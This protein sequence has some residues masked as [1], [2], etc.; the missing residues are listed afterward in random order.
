MKF[1]IAAAMLLSAACASFALAQDADDKPA[2]AVAIVPPAI[3]IAPPTRGPVVIPDARSMASEQEI[4]QARRAYRAQCSRHESTAFCECVTAGLAQALAP[5]EVRIAAR[6][7]GARINVQGDAPPV[8][9][10]TAALALD[11]P[12]ARIEAV[13]AHYAQACAQ[14]RSN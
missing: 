11:S 9:S 10:D 2:D 13:E 7:I 14:F 3:I 8:A 1:A 4:A 12:L 6:T 5:S